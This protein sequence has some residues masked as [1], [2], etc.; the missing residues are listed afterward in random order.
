MNSPLESVL[1]LYDGV[2]IR[3]R[4]L[5]PWRDGPAGVHGF[6]FWA[7]GEKAAGSS[8]GNDEVRLLHDIAITIEMES[9][10]AI[11]VAFGLSTFVLAQAR[12]E[13]VVYAIDDY[14]ERDLAG[15]HAR[16]LVKRL[17][18]DHCPNVRLTVGRSPEC[19]PVALRVGSTVD[20][21]LIDGMHTD[22]AAAAD[23]EGVRPYMSERTVVLWHDADVV[24]GAFR[25]CFE[26]SLFDRRD[27]LN[28]YGRMGVHYNSKAHPA[29]MDLLT[30]WVLP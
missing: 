28:S 3:L 5:E 20:L 6:E 18:R 15:S 14:S 21:V 26:P 17:I 29:L 9:A 24:G 2:D 16:P 12:P 10:Y 8:V 30:E 25:H 11:G 4:E 1:T 13:A 7:D 22:E 27:E 19:T 23:F